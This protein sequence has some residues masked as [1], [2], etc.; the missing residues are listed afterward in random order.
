M[1]IGVIGLG[2]MGGN[3]SVRLMRHGH[4]CVVYDAS[5]DAIARIA[6][7]GAKGAHDLADMVKQLTKPRAVWVMLPAGH[8]TEQTIEALAGMM[9]SGDTIIDGGNSFYKDDIRRAAK[10]REKGTHLR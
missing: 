1:Q 8:I 9:E 6:K 5:P 4:D 3:I 2:R 7:E 10:L